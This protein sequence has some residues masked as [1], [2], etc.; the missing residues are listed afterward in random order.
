LLH[1]G[2]ILPG[3]DFVFVEL[4][5]FH[6]THADERLV[7]LN[8]FIV[9]DP[10]VLRGGLPLTGAH[11]EERPAPLAEHALIESIL[12]YLE[13]IERTGLEPFSLRA[14]TGNH[15]RTGRVEIVVINTNRPVG[16]D[17]NAS[18][19]VVPESVATDVHPDVGLVIHGHHVRPIEIGQRLGKHVI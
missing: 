17:E 14:I 12:G 1:E 16:L 2:V 8:Y 3:H 19:A 7:D 11:G 13:I 10:D 4:E 15:R 5:V 18:S 9:V 6:V